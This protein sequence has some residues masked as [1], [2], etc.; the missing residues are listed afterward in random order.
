M[1]AKREM[2]ALATALKQPAVIR[3]V[4]PGGSPNE[5][6]TEILMAVADV[7][8]ASNPRFDRQH[9]FDYIAGR[10]GSNGGEV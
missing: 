1:I 4:H 7:C 2:I 9:W 5:L 8:A 10:C 6:Y 3:L